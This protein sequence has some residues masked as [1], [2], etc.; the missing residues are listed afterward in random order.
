M[1]TWRKETKQ[2]HLLHIIDEGDVVWWFLDSNNPGFQ[3][4]LGHLT[5]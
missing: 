1:N 4:Q 2:T 5:V 3:S